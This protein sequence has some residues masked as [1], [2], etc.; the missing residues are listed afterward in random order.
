[1]SRFPD[2]KLY[3]DVLTP[4]FCEKVIARFEADARKA[5]DPQ[6]DYSTRHYLNI[7]RCNDWLLV[8]LEFCK[9]VNTV[10]GDYFAR[11]PE[12]AAATHAEWSDDGY[13]VCRYDVGDACILHVD[14]QCSEEPNNGLRLATLVFYLNDVPV[15]GETWFPLQD[16]KVAPRRGHAVVFPVGYTHPHEVLATKSPRYIMQTWITDPHLAVVRR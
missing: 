4:A 13:V 14:G 5:P 6:P 2:I 11:P 9:I 7:S 10:M 15:G 3:P 16:V 12:V 1:M 8:N